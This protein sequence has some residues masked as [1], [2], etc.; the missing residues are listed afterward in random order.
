[1]DKY[2]NE[3]DTKGWT[4]VPD[5]LSPHEIDSALTMFKNWQQKIVNHDSMHEKINPHGNVSAS[6]LH[7]KNTSTSLL[8]FPSKK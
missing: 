7:V 6:M 2:K 5:V 3:L 1:M 8:G 4:I